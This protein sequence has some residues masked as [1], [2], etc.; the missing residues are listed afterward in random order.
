MNPYESGETTI[1]RVSAVRAP[2]HVDVVFIHGLG[3]HAKTTWMQDKT[4]DETFWPSWLAQDLPEACV[5]SAEYPAAASK[6][7][8]RGS[9]S[10]PL[11]T[12]VFALLD[13][14]SHLGFGDRPVIL[15]CHSLGG[16]VAKQLVRAAAE[17]TASDMWK[18]VGAAIKGVVFISTPHS[19]APLANFFVNLARLLFPPFLVHATASLKNLQTNS[20]ALNQLSD[21]YREAAHTDQIATLAYYEQE[22]TR[23]IQVVNLDSANPK[24]LKVTAIPLPFDHWGTSKARDRGAQVYVGTLS[25][26]R[27]VLEGL[28]PSK[29]LNLSIVSPPNGECIVPRARDRQADLAEALPEA[30]AASGLP[31]REWL[32]DKLKSYKERAVNAIAANETKGYM[33]HHGVDVDECEQFALSVE[34]WIRQTGMNI[35]MRHG[36]ET[37]AARTVCIELEV[38]NDG[39]LPAKGVE[40]ELSI[41]SRHPATTTSKT[42]FSATYGPASVP[43]PPESLASEV[44]APDEQTL[45]KIAYRKW[46]ESVT[47]A[48]AGPATNRVSLYEDRRHSPWQFQSSRFDVRQG[49]SVRLTPLYTCFEYDPAE[50][51]KITYRISAENLAGTVDG[52][53]TIHVANSE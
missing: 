12:V 36:N 53:V 38:A 8:G 20:I 9:K 19:G 13:R 48:S 41:S 15:V 33:M 29:K 46:Y 43:K 10:I 11:E 39:D 52:V 23:G 40:L 42:Y 30:I 32:V 47:S 14:F 51:I 4:N 45:K 35:I 27:E 26:I 7:L 50:D 1:H 5:W 3:G 44:G 2:A 21:W 31:S 24:L 25:F 28:P 22:P 6:W 16:L 37:Y 34:E 17:R 49:R 18:K